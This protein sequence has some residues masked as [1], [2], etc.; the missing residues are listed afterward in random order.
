MKKQSLIND[1]EK[2]WTF[3][4][5]SKRTAVFLETVAIGRGEYLPGWKWS[6]DVGKMTGK[7]SESHIGYILS[8][9]M[10]T[11]AP[12]GKE[13]KL[14]PGDAFELQPGHDAWVFGNESCIAL[15]FENL[16]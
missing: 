15:D 11:K 12:D 13:N 9:E 5:G 6:Q 14:V 16:K 8:G 4:D 2:S 7:K 1:P 3:L 10:I